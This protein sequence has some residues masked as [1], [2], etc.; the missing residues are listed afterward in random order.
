M[1]S[2]TGGRM[3]LDRE[4]S[5]MQLDQ[6]YAWMRSRAAPSRPLRAQPRMPAGEGGR[7]FCR[8]IH[9]RAF[10][11]RVPPCRLENSLGHHPAPCPRAPRRRYGETVGQFGRALPPAVGAMARSTVSRKQGSTP[12]TSRR[13]V[14]ASHG[15]TWELD[16]MSRRLGSRP[17]VLV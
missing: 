14:T 6:Q 15:G 1:T 3:E 11:R 5:C 13:A 8:H 10:C 17:K 2:S 9:P 16:A 7:A 4:H 12:A